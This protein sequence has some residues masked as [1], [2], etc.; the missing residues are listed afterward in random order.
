MAEGSG[1]VRT[2]GLDGTPQMECLYP[3]PGI[4]AAGVGEPAHGRVGGDCGD[5]LRVYVRGGAEGYELL[6]VGVPGRPGEALARQFKPEARTP[7]EG[8]GKYGGVAA[9]RRA[10]HFLLKMRVQ[11]DNFASQNCPEGVHGAKAT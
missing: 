4:Y 8:E 1:G 5:G 11:Y 6:A 10:R 2:P 9:T 7:S 3:G